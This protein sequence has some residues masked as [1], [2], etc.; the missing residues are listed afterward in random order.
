L[1]TRYRPTEKAENLINNVKQR[2]KGII[3]IDK[4]ISGEIQMP[5]KALFVFSDIAG[6]TWLG[7]IFKTK[8]N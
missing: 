4:V 5:I 3:D 8:Y 2:F 1:T 7:N 6:Y